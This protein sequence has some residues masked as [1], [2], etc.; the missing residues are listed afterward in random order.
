MRVFACITMKS[1]E[2]GS[3]VWLIKFDWI[4]SSSDDDTPTCLLY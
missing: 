2:P 4:L 3:A 1:L